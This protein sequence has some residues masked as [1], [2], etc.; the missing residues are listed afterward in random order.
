MNRRLLLSLC[1]ASSSV[2]AQPTRQPF[3]KP[4]TGYAGLG[5]E[6]VSP[7]EVAKFAPPPLDP[8]VSRRIQAMLDV[9]GA[10]TGHVTNK[11]NRLFFTSAITGSA[12][13]WRQDGPMAFARQ[14]TGGEDRTG[15]AAMSPDEKYLVVSRDIS[16]EENP[17][18]YVMNPDGGP[19]QVIQHTPKV[20]TALEFIADD[21]KTLVF[22]ANDI[23]A[24][25]YALYRYDVATKKKELVFDQPGLWDVADHKGTG[26]NETW[27]L[28]KRLGNTQVEIYL[29]E[30]ASR[31]LTPLLGQNENED[32]AARFG[33]KPGQLLVL[34]NKLGEYHRLYSLDTATSGAK[35]VPI[36]PEL[37][38]EVAQF[39][40]DQPRARIYYEVNEDG[41]RRLYALDAKTFKPLTLPKLKADN[42]S[43]A[44]ASRNGRYI[45]LTVDGSRLPPTS[46][47]YDWQTR[48]AVTWQLPMTPE[49]DT[50]T[51]ANAQLEYYPARDGTKIPMFVRRPASCS[52]PC[53]V[54]VDFHGG[55]E[56]QSTAGFAPQ[57]Q[58]YVDA[59][60]TY[61][62][63]NVRGSVGYGK[64]WLH[65]DNGPK[66]LAV[67]TDIEDVAKYIRVAWARDGKAPK[68]GVIGGS[69]GGYST[70][71]AMT[72]FAGAYDAGVQTVGISN[73]ST[74]LINTA[75]YRRILR[76]SEY[77]DPV[78]DKDALVQLSPITHV[79]KIKAPLLSIQGVNDPRV[80]VGEA[81]QI[82]RELERRKIPGGLILFADEGH[83]TSK[84]SNR[85]LAVGHTIAFLE[86]Y[87]MNK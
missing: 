45:Q 77:G 70:L 84:R 74:F 15:V 49:I 9:R 78:K 63:P 57:A 71:M 56:G 32:Y 21:S 59:G 5:A 75:P 69:Y 29:F 2:S 36:T 26:K 48:K 25:S 10:S 31:K 30:V 86:K 73:L 17:G 52:G 76:I 66:R 22:R 39:S 64:A 19:L 87:L 60:F 62:Q 61:V 6:S 67:I 51:F 20:Q 28:A 46:V 12:Q 79:N 80:P 16:G 55:P 33:A 44:G 24:A 53:P 40:I 14:L 65:A 4:A 34:T 54:V 72:Y 7:A 81:I 1:L 27:L 43:Y 47:T 13:V 8:K 35:L 3:A 42:V 41:Y 85:V 18:L 38:H 83:G 23:D 58:L 37:K 82:Y 11:G 68:I 50:T